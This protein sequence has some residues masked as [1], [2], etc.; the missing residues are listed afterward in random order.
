LSPNEDP[1]TISKRDMWINRLKE[2]GV[3]EPH[4]IYCRMY[5]PYGD[6]V[7]EE[8]EYKRLFGFLDRLRCL[9]LDKTID[10]IE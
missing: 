9:R 10:L 8:P 1:F 6:E 3:T 5:R 2:I 4:T 7:N